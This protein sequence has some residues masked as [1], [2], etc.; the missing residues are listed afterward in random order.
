MHVRLRDSHLTPIVGARR[1][2][3][4]VRRQHFLEP[5]VRGCR[6]PAAA[7]VIARLDTPIATTLHGAFDSAERKQGLLGRDQLAEGGAMILAPCAAVHTWFM[8]FPIDVVFAARDGTVVKIAA[9][10]RPWRIAIGWGAFA[11][12]EL[13]SGTASRCGLKVGDR[14]KIVALGH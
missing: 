2:L 6:T 11:A 10:T 7:L 8:R 14:L 1:T 4:A 9:A 12:I 3:R 5:L 13:P